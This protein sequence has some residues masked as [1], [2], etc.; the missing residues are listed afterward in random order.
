MTYANFEFTCKEHGT[1]VSEPKRSVDVNTH[2]HT[3]SV[4]KFLWLVK[5]NTAGDDGRQ[6]VF[7]EL[8]SAFLITSPTA[9][10]DDS[11]RIS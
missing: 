6:E 11:Q 9:L 4:N 7:A 3:D 1:Y 5:T 10:T 2:T 8:G